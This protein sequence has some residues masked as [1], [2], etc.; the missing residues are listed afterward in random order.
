MTCRARCMHVLEGGTTTPV[1]AGRGLVP[2]MRTAAVVEQSWAVGTA[3]ASPGAV[4]CKA[5]IPPPDVRAMPTCRNLRSNNL[6]G[7]L[8]TEWSALTALTYL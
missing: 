5:C 7:T 2:R 1:N 3:W 8:P 6:S 4:S